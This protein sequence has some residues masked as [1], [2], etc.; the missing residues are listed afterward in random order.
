MLKNNNFKTIKRQNKF[1]L[2]ASLK[3]IYLKLKKI[4]I[5]Q[6]TKLKIDTKKSLLLLIDFKI[7]IFFS[8]LAK[9]ILYYFVC[10]DNFF[11]IKSIIEYYIKFSLASTLKQK[12]KISSIN[13]VFKIYGKNISVIHPYKKNYR[14]S[15]ITRFSVNN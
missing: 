3:L 2:N 14:I 15:F 4:G 10:C 1:T 5:F 11:K 13:K 6:Q 9:N 8:S 12:H 7:I